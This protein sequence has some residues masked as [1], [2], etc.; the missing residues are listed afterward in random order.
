MVYYRVKS[1]V[2]MFYFDFNT[3]VPLNCDALFFGKTYVDMMSF[4]WDPNNIL[5]QTLIK[6]IA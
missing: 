4:G 5:V 1:R 2:Q 3:S 6:L